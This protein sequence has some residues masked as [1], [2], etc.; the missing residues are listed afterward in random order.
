M[1]ILIKSWAGEQTRGLVLV[2]FFLS[3]SQTV[4]SIVNEQYELS[5]PTQTRENTAHFGSSRTPQIA[6]MND[7]L[8][9]ATLSL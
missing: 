8:C 7:H 4:V 2:F 1:G 5:S 3:R 6:I 9:Q